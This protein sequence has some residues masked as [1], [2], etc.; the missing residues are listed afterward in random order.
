MNGEERGELTAIL[1][2]VRAGCP[3]AQERLIRA[4][5]SELRRRAGG[6]M[7]HERGDHT[8]QASALVHEALLRLLGGDAL[9]LKSQLGGSEP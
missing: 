5:Y 9:A 1:N 7:R 2:E 4:I 8:L 6:L 3:D